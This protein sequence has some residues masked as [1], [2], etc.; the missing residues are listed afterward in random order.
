[1]TI[2]SSVGPPP[3]W[4][5][6]SGTAAV[7][8]LREMRMDI[9]PTTAYLMLG[10]R[11]SRNCAFCSQARE[12]HAS[13]AALSRVIWPQFGI[14]DIVRGI[15]SAEARG[16]IGRICL[17]VTASPGYV[18][19]TRE[20]LA[21]LSP[22]TR[23]PI[24]ACACARNMDDIE[25]LLD[26]GAS[27]VTV[28]LDAATL[29]LFRAI[30]GSP[31]DRTL[32][33]LRDA[34]HN[35]P[36]QI[37]THLIVGLGETERDMVERIDTLLGWGVAV[38]LFAFTPVRGTAMEGHRPPDLARYRRIQAAFWLLRHNLAKAAEYEY[39]G[40]GRIAS[41]GLT[42]EKL[43]EAVQGGAAFRTSGCDSCN[44]PYYNERPGGVIYNYARPLTPEEARQEI[45]A[46]MASL[47]GPRQDASR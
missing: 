4:R 33:L 17:Q 18:E 27:R 37:G 24:C 3:T 29:D 16:A 9:A 26:A 10:E 40:V 11:C 15:A 12:S 6:S 38:G 35:H 44:R 30:K 20:A 22:H 5:V 23:L 41:L 21:I 19:L 46:L 42:G 36:G 45:D 43:A 39:D 1:M 8:G 25:L 32:G 34:A 31:P 14:D 13:A 2:P 47:P 28:A 7:L